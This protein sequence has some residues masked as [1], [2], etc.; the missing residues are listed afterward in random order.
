MLRRTPRDRPGVLDLPRRT[1]TS[2]RLRARRARTRRRRSAR[3]ARSRP[4]ACAA[5]S[6]P[7]AAASRRTWHGWFDPTGYVKGWAVESRS[8]PA[9]RTRCSSPGSSPSAST[10]AATCSCSPRDGS[11]WTLD[12]SASPTRADPERSSR[13]SRCATA[14]SRPPAP[15]AR[16]S[17]IIDPR[18]GEPATGVRERDGRRGRPHARRRL[19]DRGGRRR[20][21]RPLVDRAARHPHRHRR[22]AT[23]A[24]VQPLARR[25]IESTWSPPMRRW[26]ELSRRPAERSR[27]VVPASEVALDRHAAAAPHRDIAHER[28]A[29]ARSC[30]GD[31][32]RRS[33]RSA[34][35]GVGGDAA[36]AG[37][38]VG[39]ADLPRAPSSTVALTRRPPLPAGAVLHRVV[40]ERDARAA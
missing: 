1:P 4:P 15:R 8:P 32:S 23:T 21:R 25:H 28:R 14:R 5:G 39:D 3:R 22:R 38:V 12:A 33:A 6:E 19:G 26:P 29:R 16:R 34:R 36:D 27:K 9:P 17:H 11:D 20:V 31:R 10:P 35:R 2:R 30:G 24:A 37:S 18:T 7:R 40:E 13:R